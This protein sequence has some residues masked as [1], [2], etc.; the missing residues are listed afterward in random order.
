MRR[1]TGNG[2]SKGNISRC[3]FAFAPA[4]GRA[5]VAAR[6]LFD[7]GLKSRSTQKQRQKQTKQPQEQT[8]TTAT[9]T[10]TADPYGMTNKGTSNSN[11]KNNGNDDCLGGIEIW[12]DAELSRMG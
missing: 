3:G 2:K 1:G 8:T 11:G 4:F 9:A 5:E 10:A 6:R 7:A 12:H